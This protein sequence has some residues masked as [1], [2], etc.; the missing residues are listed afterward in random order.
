MNGQHNFKNSRFKTAVERINLMNMLTAKVLPSLDDIDDDSSFSINQK[1]SLGQ[2]TNQPRIL[3]TPKATNR[4]IADRWVRFEDAHLQRQFTRRLDDFSYR[5]DVSFVLGLAFYVLFYVFLD[6]IYMNTM[7][8]QPMYT[9]TTYRYRISFRI[10]SAILLGCLARYHYLKSSDQPNYVPY[11]TSKWWLTRSNA[12]LVGVTIFFIALHVVGM[13]SGDTWSTTTQ[14]RIFFELCV[15]FT[16]RPYEKLNAIICVVTLGIV[17]PLIWLLATMNT[18]QKVSGVADICKSQINGIQSFNWDPQAA[19]LVAIA[20]LFPFVIERI[21]HFRLLNMALEFVQWRR[22]RTEELEQLLTCGNKEYGIADKRVRHGSIMTHTSIYSSNRSDTSD[23]VEPLGRG[24]NGGGVRGIKGDVEEGKGNVDGYKDQGGEGG[25]GEEENT[26]TSAY[27]VQTKESRYVTSLE[28]VDHTT[29]AELGI[30]HVHRVLD[31]LDMPKDYQVLLRDAIAIMRQGPKIFEPNIIEQLSRVVAGGKHKKSIF[32]HMG[33][34][35]PTN[36]NKKGSGGLFS[37]KK[38]ISPHQLVGPLGSEA[39]Q[40]D[41][42]Q[43]LVKTKTVTNVFDNV[44]SNEHLLALDIDTQHMMRTFGSEHFNV[45]D[46]ENNPKQAFVAAGIMVLNDHYM[47]Q[48]FRLDEIKVLRALQRFADI[49]NTPT[50]VPYHSQLHGVDVAQLSHL[51]LSQ[52]YKI[53]VGSSKY[54]GCPLD[55]VH[56]FALIFGALVHDL[57]HPGVNNSFLTE[58]SSPMAL[59]FNDISVLEMFHV[60]STFQVLAKPECDIFE[61]L[62]H[63]ER[64]KIRSVMIELILATD[65]ADHFKSLKTIQTTLNIPSVDALSFL[66]IGNVSNVHMLGG[67]TLPHTL[68]GVEQSELGKLILKAADIGHPARDPVSHQEWS[69]RASEEFWRQGDRERRL[70]LPVNPMND[71]RESKGLAKGQMGFLSFLVA[72]THFTLRCAIGVLKLPQ[73]H[74][75]LRNNYQYWER[76]S[77]QTSIKQNKKIEKSKSNSKEESDNDNDSGSSSGMKTPV[78][79]DKVARKIFSSKRPPKPS[80]PHPLENIEE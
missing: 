6:V 27:N 63:D 5:D 20:F 70:G 24:G 45:F 77:Q 60:S 57:G 61:Q 76:M 80:A 68:T 62:E 14:Y 30:A 42:R 10:L 71:R 1:N 35:S 41:R 75:N 52:L 25:G 8:M 15:M 11:G 29:P 66:K 56:R 40:Q 12:L 79:K 17:T 67:Y 78:P 19:T 21:C 38:K 2:T 53:E 69:R 36:S 43:M 16:L 34:G 47:F 31:Q 72:P 74:E 22:L 59:R 73:L 50:D 26:L 13:I 64:A 3:V 65:L 4:I 51:Y 28:H 49:Y 33:L 48:T 58:T 7:S 44:H 46:Y 9:N 39:L 23:D 37:P 54:E 18:I 32:S 55:A